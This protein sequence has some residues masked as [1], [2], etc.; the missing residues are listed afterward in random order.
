MK[1][2]LQTLTT[3]NHIHRGLFR[4]KKKIKNQ[5]YFFTFK[6]I[7]R[8]DLINQLETIECYGYKLSQVFQSKEFSVLDEQIVILKFRMF[9]A[10]KI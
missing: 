8:D 3:L 10:T 1:K 4:L 5:K 7:S 9:P 2:L 6:T